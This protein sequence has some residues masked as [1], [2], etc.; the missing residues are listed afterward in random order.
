M[1]TTYIRTPGPGNGNGKR[2]KPSCTAVRGLVKKS[3]VTIMNNDNLCCARAIVTMKA[4]VDGN[5]NTQDRDYK[6]L[7]Q[8]YPVQ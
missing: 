4:L 6:N 3:R 1:E 7:K 2:Y 5:G 8:G